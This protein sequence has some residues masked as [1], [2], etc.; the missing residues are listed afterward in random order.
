MRQDVQLYFK[1]TTDKLAKETKFR[2][3]MIEDALEV[4]LDTNHKAWDTL[5]QPYLLHNYKLASYLDPF[6]NFS[7]E[8]W[9]TP[10]AKQD[11]TR[12]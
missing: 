5:T 3:Y 8:F 6:L 7:E 10:T 12:I 2:Q 11:L 9:D 1:Q 4:V